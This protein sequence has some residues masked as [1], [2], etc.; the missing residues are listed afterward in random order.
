MDESRD[1]GTSWNTV[2]AVSEGR[3][4]ALRRH[5][6][7]YSVTAWQG[8]AAIAVQ[9]V[10]DGHVVVAANGDDGIAVRDAR[11]NWRRLGLSEGGFSA[12]AAVPLNAP[13]VDLTTEHRIGLFSG[14]LAFMVGV[15]MAGRH[16]WRFISLT[17]PA[18]VFASVGFV[19]ALPPGRPSY[20]IIDF[21][22]L[23]ALLG[24]ACALVAA[25]FAVAAAINARVPA[26]T[27]LAL[28]TIASCTPFSIWMLFTGWESGVID[29]YS[30]AGFLAYLVG[31]AGI[32]ASALVGRVGAAEV[33]EVERSV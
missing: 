24:G 32:G 3:Q 33:A 16:G 19:L 23:V 10:P 14:L 28:V 1:G 13:D 25:V 22:A 27:W 7:D 15:T 2:W 12:D 6:E 17:V 11:G 4:D 26:R 31:G 21:G 29:A 9:R 18:Y 5:T 30:T 20:G 8:S